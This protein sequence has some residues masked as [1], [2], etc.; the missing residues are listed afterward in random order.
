MDRLHSR[1]AMLAA[2]LALL[3]AAAAYLAVFAAGQ[4]RPGP[5]SAS[6]R[7]YLLEDTVPLSCVVIR[8][9]TA[10]AVSRQWVR[11]AVNDGVR[12]AAGEAAAIVYDSA[13]EYM[14][15][16]LLLRLRRELQDLACASSAPAPEAILS[17]VRSE[18]SAALVRK[19]FDAVNAAANDLALGL[20]PSAA[21]PAAAG[22]LREEILSLEAAGAADGLLTADSGSVWSS[23][24]DG[25]E[26]LSPAR[27]RELDFET[28][29][30]VLR[31]PVLARGRAGKLVAD[32]TWL[33]AALTD[34]GTGALFPPGDTFEVRTAACGLS[35]EVIL[36][37]TQGERAMVVFR[38]RE[39]LEQVLDERVL[40][41]EVVLGRTEGL[42]LPED[43]IRR[44]EGGTFVYRIAGQLL[45]RT[46]VTPLAEAPEGVFVSS[47]ALR[48]G[49]GVL[50]GDAEDSGM[51]VF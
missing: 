41:A 6:V 28:L 16:A 4:L 34:S 25:W 36:L 35:G 24:T 51:L 39:G 8:E 15:A 49:D 7:E 37:R 46:A 12:L 47:D 42:L 48:P 32:S 33:M 38:C 40:S 31:A 10:L 19:D 27:L 20:L 5:E 13:G 26:A 23:Y 17:E 44:E 1:V 30:A 18:L 29:D 11:P 3:T 9:E 50:L 14:R 2:G 45:V 43:A 21:A 22:R